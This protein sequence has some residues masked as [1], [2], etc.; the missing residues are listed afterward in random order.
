MT[1]QPV[2]FKTPVVFLAEYERIAR[3]NRP[4]WDQFI[5]DAQQDPTGIAYEVMDVIAETAPN[6]WKV[7]KNSDE[8][9]NAVF[10][11]TVKWVS[12]L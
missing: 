10:N 6:F 1:D 2:A 4:D 11:V 12:E 5:R 3:R 9:W 7:M 8:Y